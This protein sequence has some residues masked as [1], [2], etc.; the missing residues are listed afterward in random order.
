VTQSKFF[1]G[2]FLKWVTLAGFALYCPFSF[3]HEQVN[4]ALTAEIIEKIMDSALSRARAMK[5]PMAIAI[6]NSE[7]N[8]VGFIRMEGARL[9]GRYTSESKAYT[10]AS[11]C[12]PSHATEI[13]GEVERGISAATQGR[14]VNIS[15]GM[16]LMVSGRCIGAIGVSGGNGEQDMEVAKAGAQAIK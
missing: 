10:S 15:G 11:T 16:P 14:Y 3:A 4:I 2:R 5:I 9:H 13:P 8:L 1:F 12:K 6:V 7:G